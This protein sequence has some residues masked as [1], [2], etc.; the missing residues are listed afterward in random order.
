MTQKDLSTVIELQ[1]FLMKMGYVKF[2]AYLEMNYHTYQSFVNGKK[3]TSPRTMK[4]L[5]KFAESKGIDVNGLK[6]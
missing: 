5:K 3:K 6:L 1:R 2:A 4:I